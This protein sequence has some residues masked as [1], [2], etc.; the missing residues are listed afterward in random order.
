MSPNVGNV[1]WLA[2]ES[3]VV[4]KQLC[5]GEVS[6]PKRVHARKLSHVSQ[7]PP[8]SL[9]PNVVVEKNVQV[10]S[11]GVNTNMLAFEEHGNFL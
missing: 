8:S 3:Q 11:K 4:A 7:P 6:S 9:Q 1:H 10:G 2:L 5:D